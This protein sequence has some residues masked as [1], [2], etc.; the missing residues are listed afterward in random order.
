MGRRHRP[1]RRGGAGGF[2]SGAPAGRRRGVQQA[3]GGGGGGSRRRRGGGRPRS[4]LPAR[5]IL[6]QAVFHFHAPGSL[7]AGAGAAHGGAVPTRGAAAAAD[8]D[9]T[10][11]CRRAE[12]GCALPAGRHGRAQ[13]GGGGGPPRRRSR[14]GRRRRRRR[15]SRAPAAA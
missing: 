2:L 8:T 1:R 9:A 13:A 11:G 7:A 4:R 12:E 14:G 5:A 15:R 10:P 6:A 3:G